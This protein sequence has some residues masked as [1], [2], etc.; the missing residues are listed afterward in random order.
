MKRTSSKVLRQWVNH[1]RLCETLFADA[2]LVLEEL[3]RRHDPWGQRELGMELWRSGDR[4]RAYGLIKAA[5]KQGDKTAADDMKN[6][7]RDGRF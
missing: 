3:V 7:N 6:F 1:L 4:H 2:N 5:A